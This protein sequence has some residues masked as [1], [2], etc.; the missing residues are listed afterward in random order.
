MKVFMSS[1]VFKSR[2]C[3]CLVSSGD[4]ALAIE[5]NHFTVLHNTWKREYF[6]VEGR[7]SGKKIAWS[8]V[9]YAMGMIGYFFE[10]VLVKIILALGNTLAFFVSLCRGDSQWMHKRA[11][12]CL[13]SW[14]ALGIGII[15]ILIP[16]LAYRLDAAAKETIIG[17]LRTY[18]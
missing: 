7:L 5:E 18:P 9:V 8:F 17:L 14:T 10:T 4:P 6:Y 15:G 2:E 11:I 16:P 3:I 12:L 13:D 1:P